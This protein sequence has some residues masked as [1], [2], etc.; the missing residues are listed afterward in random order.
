[1]ANADISWSH[2]HLPIHHGELKI[3][4]PSYEAQRAHARAKYYAK[5]AHDLAKLR[6][7]IYGI[8]HGFYGFRYGSHFPRHFPKPFPLMPFINKY[9]LFDLGFHHYPFSSFMPK[10]FFFYPPHIP[11]ISEPLIG[12]GYPKSYHDSYSHSYSHGSG[13]SYGKGYSY[14][15][16]YSH[17]HKHGHEFG[18]PHYGYAFKKEFPEES[19]LYKPH[20]DGYEY[21]YV[22]KTP[23]YGPSSDIGGYG[24][25]AFDADVPSQEHDFFLVPTKEI[26]L[27]EDSHEGD[28]YIPVHES[29]YGSFADATPNADLH[30]MRI[31]G[32][33]KYHK[34][35][36]T[37]FIAYGSEKS[38]TRKAKEKLLQNKLI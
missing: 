17:G 23:D 21:A 18:N 2:D 6:S 35:D 4:H 9:P 36:E 32:Y 5:R 16:G 25:I 30:T 19:A 20:S 15:K 28:T 24:S 33:P 13:Y 27:V 37:D 7:S 3:F 10:H 26:A 8:G 34:F 12:F 38:E 14:K 11:S 31:L 1:M 29:S 22:K